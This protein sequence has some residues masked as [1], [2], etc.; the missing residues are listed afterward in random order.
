MDAPP[1]EVYYPFGGRKFLLN[2]WTYS[3]RGHVVIADTEAQLLKIAHKVFADNWDAEIKALCE[4]DIRAPSKKLC[5]EAAERTRRE[6]IDLF[7]REMAWDIKKAIEARQPLPVGFE[8]CV[9]YDNPDADPEGDGPSSSHWDCRNCVEGVR[10]GGFSRDELYERYHDR[11]RKE[12]H[13]DHRRPAR[14]PKRPYPQVSRAPQAADEDELHTAVADFGHHSTGINLVDEPVYH[15]RTPLFFFLPVRDLDQTIFKAILRERKDAFKRAEQERDERRRL[16]WQREK[17][18]DIRKT[19]DF[20]NAERLDFVT[21][22]ARRLQDERAGEAR[23][24]RLEAALESFENPDI[25]DSVGGPRRS[26]P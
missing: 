14:D 10:L 24:A 15:N 23:A 1:I 17:F 20:I 13:P 22:L 19:C 2:W 4:V 6:E 26:I 18:R 12:I 7:A 11:W 9:Q 3:D 8:R 5:L 25:C 16:E 21:L